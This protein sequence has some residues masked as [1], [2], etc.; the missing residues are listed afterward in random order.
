MDGHDASS[1]RVTE[2][3]TVNAAVMERRKFLETS[4]YI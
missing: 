2:L 1:F 4:I 3:N